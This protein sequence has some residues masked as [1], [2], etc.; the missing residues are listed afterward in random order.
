[1]P[2]AGCGSQPA[3]D[4]SQIK[5]KRYLYATID[6]RK[7]TRLRR[8]TDRIQRHR[9]SNPICKELHVKLDCPM[10][11]ANNPETGNAANLI[12]DSTKSRHMQE[13]LE[14][15]QPPL[16]FAAQLRIHLRQSSLRTQIGL[17]AGLFLILILVSQALLLFSA[18]RDELKQSLS[19]QLEV[20]VNQVAT[21]LDDKVLMR[22]AFLEAMARKF[23]QS[24]LQNV[25]EAER[26]FRD[27]AIL[28]I[29]IDD[30][31][32][33]SAEGSLL[34]D[35][36]IAP[37]RRGLDMTDRDYIQGVIHKG[38]TTVSKP[39][40]GRATKQPMVVIAVPIRNA[41]GKL[42][43]I[44]G[45][46]V[47][48][49]KS[50]LLE[51]LST[52]RVGQTGYFYL[53][54]PERLTIM[55][56]DRTKILKPITA[57]GMNPA[58]DRAL[59][60]NFEGTVEGVDS[61]GIKGLFSFKRLPHTGWV[62]AAV[63]PSSEALAAVN[64]L[65][66]RV[67]LLTALSLIL[68]IAVIMLIVR[69]FTRP[70]ELLTDFLES[71]R[72]LSHPPALVHSCKETD[73]LSDAFSNFVVQ[74]KIT[75]EK[76]SIATQ[77]AEA[78]NADLRI[79][80]IAFESQEGMFI[81]DAENVILRINQ[82]FTDITGY[83][84]AEAVG[85]TPD[86]F[87]SGRHDAKFF[88]AMYDSLQRSRAWQGEI[89]NHRKNGEIH[90]VWLTITAVIDSEGALTH[91]VSTLTDIS[92]RKA[93]EKEI[94]YLAFYDPL[95][96]LPNRRLL[97]DRVQ[98][99]LA[100]SARSE[101]TGALLFIDLDNFKMLNDTLGHDKGDL[102]L[103]QVA[104]RLSTCVREGDSIAR[105]GGDEFVL[106][107]ED[108]SKDTNEAATQAEA[109]GEKILAALYHPYDLAG[110]EYHNTPSIGVTLFEN[111]KNSI[112]ELMKHADLAMYEAKKAGGNTLR[113][114]DPQMQATITGRAVLE[115]DLRE[116]LQ[117]GQLLVYYQP[118]VDA[119]GRITGME[120]L[121]RWQH[122]QRGL[123]SPADF[124][125]LAE[126]TG[127]ILPIGQWVLK[128]ACNQLLAW[129]TK[130]G[131]SHLTVAVNVSARQF[132]QPDFVEQVLAVLDRSGANPQK[133]KLELT[134]SLLLENV[135]EVITKM[136]ALKARGISFS[137][138]DFGTGYSSL[139]YLKRLPL[140][141]L[142][143]DQSFVRDL[144]TD[145]NDAAIARTIVALAQSLGLS[146][147][148]EGVETEAQ[149]DCLATQG[150]RAY[151]G[152]LFGRPMPLADFE[153]LLLQPAEI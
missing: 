136:T 116:A 117:E 34:V 142:K 104:Q 118:Q 84:T 22:V 134:E 83:T 89:W 43:G 103:Q 42:M 49:Q 59:N 88:A 141:Q 36:P 126:E 143:I 18:A 37:G 122:P 48:L 128:T 35:W 78:A 72:T 9:M 130:P 32:L 33:F 97:I 74:Q 40:M 75:Q 110:H 90:P 92:Q 45:G 58:L 101:R 66:L 115:K 86:L 6:M 53:V 145:P 17:A 138:D 19:G 60:E 25:S 64:K 111:H 124:I 123:V 20:L 68:T 107:L 39:I 121:V 31:Y 100:S 7:F 129:A 54:G 112:D 26:Y 113:F 127:L 119:T 4:L 85:Q 38:Q 106:V 125:P 76:L 52:T 146:V 108:L 55:H 102:L 29:L 77:R 12:L 47:N 71:T 96:R 144:L 99:A 150:C 28:S 11:N 81:T 137:L 3:H 24:A 16:R 70:L 131:R 61:R 69:R 132:R 93:A 94:Q 82:A 120:A 27:S 149:R 114:F 80:A 8:R 135:E 87:G 148:A 95:T 91:Y 57:L 73:R 41:E 50:R 151:Q 21:E 153:L 140:D 51:P 63:L 79:A 147:I 105:I 56:P 23:P 5:A 98:Q 15:C 152:Y 46:V 133:L 1:M 44:L 109:I 14:R 62:L 67:T 139:S 30:L 10:S 65:R 13:K 2:E